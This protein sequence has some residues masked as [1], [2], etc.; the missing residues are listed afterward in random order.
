MPIWK[1][2]PDC[3]GYWWVSDISLSGGGRT[4]AVTEVRMCADMQTVDFI[5]QLGTGMILGLKDYRDALWLKLEEPDL[6]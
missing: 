2:R 4:L 6:P 5:E 1:T 3:E